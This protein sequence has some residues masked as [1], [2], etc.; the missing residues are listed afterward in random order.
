METLEIDSLVF[1]VTYENYIKNLKQDKSNKTLGQWNIE[2]DKL[3][4]IKYAYAVL[5]A[6]NQMIVKKYHVEK[7]E[8]SNPEK[9]FDNPE[10][11]CLVF[12][13]SEDLF[14]DY[15]NVV[16]G[17]QYAYSHVLDNSERISSGEVEMRLMSSKESKSEGSKSK[18]LAPTTIEKLIEVKN[19]LFKD[20][21][22]PSVADV[23]N[24]EKQVENGQSAEEVLTNYFKSL[25][26]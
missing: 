20:K 12:S 10:K 6:S 13:K 23:P 24:L 26:K 7:M 8:Q 5:T 9:G 22:M 15:P 17:R 25:E 11:Y 21:Q 2:E 18:K 19:T 4:K 3:D 14:V 1:S 16:Q